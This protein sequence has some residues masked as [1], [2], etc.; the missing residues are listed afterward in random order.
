[1]FDAGSQLQAQTLDEG[2]RRPALRSLWGDALRR[3]TR[4]RGA[5]LG[6]ALVIVFV[7]LGLFAPA[8]V[9]YSPSQQHVADGFAPAFEQRYWFGAD[10]LGRDEFSR[11]LYGLRLSLEVGVVVQGVVLVVG[12]AVG[13]AA[14]L[15]SPRVDNLLMR[16]TDIFYAFPDLL[17]IILLQEAFGTGLMQIFLAIGLVAWVTVARL[18]RGQILS[19]KQRDF[20]LAARALGAS[21]LRIAVWHLLPNSISPVIVAVTFGIPA[22]I[23]TEATL[24]FIGFGLPPPTAS[25]GT[26]AAEGQQAIFAAPTLVI[27]PVL[28]IALIMFAFTFLGDGLRDALDPT[29]R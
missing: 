6:L 1:V 18:V 21:P 11:V 7:I 28:A 3:L 19:L 15:G 22:A 10:Q 23:F 26:L 14:G 29:S 25:L 17:L 16:M 2:V 8:L 27:F 13:A 5:M 24:S 20:V 4:N 12:I 9:R